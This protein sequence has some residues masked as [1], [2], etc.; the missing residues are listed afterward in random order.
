MPIQSAVVC[1][2]CSRSRDAIGR[3]HARRGFAH[4]ARASLRWDRSSATERRR[5]LEI[6]DG[7]LARALGAGGLAPDTPRASRCCASPGRRSR[8]PSRR[9]ARR[10]RAWSGARVERLHDHQALRAGDLGD[11]R[12]R[13]L[14]AG[15]RVRG[16]G[17][18][19]RGVRRRGRHATSRPRRRRSVAQ[20]RIMPA[21]HRRNRRRG[22]SVVRVVSR[23]QEEQP[24]ELE[25]VVVEVLLGQ[26][27]AGAR[28]AARRGSR[29][30]RA[31]RR[32]A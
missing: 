3:G 22:V 2:R 8:A 26:L 1:P 13:V 10:R 21:V 19:G 27:Q 5:P 15:G 31:C 12:R 29:R 23:L 32:A 4:E 7:D 30:G 14:A 24:R 6:A 18:L 16:Y 20:R 25:Q 17:A 28:A 11:L 9:S